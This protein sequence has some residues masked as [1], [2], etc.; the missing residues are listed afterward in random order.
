MS[1][2]ST[3]KKTDRRR[4]SSNITR[5]L[6]YR[7]DVEPL[8]E[9]I[10]AHSP[11][12]S[13]LD[14]HHSSNSNEDGIISSRHSLSP[15]NIDNSSLFGEG[16]IANSVVSTIIDGLHHSIAHWKVL[17][18]GQL[19]SFFIAATGAM[20][21]ELNSTCNLHIPLTQISLV[22]I[23]LM[24]LGAVN[25][26]GWCSG[27]RN[28]RIKKKIDISEGEEEQFNCSK[29]NQLNNDEDDL[30]ISIKSNIVMDDGWNREEDNEKYPTTPRRRLSNQPRSFCFGLQTIHAP[31]WAYFLLALIAIEG[32]FFV[33]A[34]FQYTYSL[35]WFKHSRYQV[36][37]F[38]A[39]CY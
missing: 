18:F 35:I 36:L 17:L 23:V 7:A 16:S 34:S 14:K 11:L 3:E 30:S 28:N 24:F 12:G 8:Q 32:R 26:R 22:G 38:S 27:C 19:I 33:I 15:I 21:E 13:L 6:S 20:S 31:S 1:T 37:W 29:N 2:S 25:M 39:S 5:S 10:A 4:P 9:A